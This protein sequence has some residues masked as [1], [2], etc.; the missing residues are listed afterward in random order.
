M[1]LGV[2]GGHRGHGGGVLILARVIW[3]RLQHIVQVNMDWPPFDRDMCPENRLTLGW[4]PCSHL[5]LTECVVL[6]GVCS[7]FCCSVKAADESGVSPQ[8]PET[9]SDSLCLVDM[10]GARC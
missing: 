3:K 4:D 2:G 9:N 7:S 6:R 1:A 8:S 10:S 5:A